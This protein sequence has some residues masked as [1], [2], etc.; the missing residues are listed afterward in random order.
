MP[1]MDIFVTNAARPGLDQNLKR[2][3]LS[4]SSLKM[5]HVANGHHGVFTLLV[6]L[7][8]FVMRNLDGAA[9]DEF[10][11]DGVAGDETGVGHLRGREALDR[12]QQLLDPLIA[13]AGV[14]EAGVGL[15]ILRLGQQ[16]FGPQKNGLSAGRSKGNPPLTTWS[17]RPI[18]G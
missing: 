18:R 6:S 11:D 4:Y 5:P 7:V 10:A 17:A 3:L 12:F 16:P 14:E 8:L 1:G 15:K 2:E 13:D 9:A